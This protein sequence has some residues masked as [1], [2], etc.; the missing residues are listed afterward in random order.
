MDKD[1][2]GMVPQRRE[3]KNWKTEETMERR[4]AEEVDARGSRPN[5]V[6]G[7]SACGGG[8]TASTTARA[9]VRRES[10]T[11]SGKKK[12]VQSLS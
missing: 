5:H 9:P 11:A 2:D 8:P 10:P 12:P 1:P 4:L 3:T 7:L 6:E